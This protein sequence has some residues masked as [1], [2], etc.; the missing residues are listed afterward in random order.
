MRASLLA[1]MTVLLAACGS[2]ALKVGVSSTADIN[3]NEFDEPLAVVVRVYQLRDPQR[4][5]EATFEE[6]WREDY[7]VLGNDLVM[8]EE[9]TMD[10][11]YQ[12]RIDMPRHDQAKHVAA[13][14]VFRAPEDTHWRD[15]KPM[16]GN[17]LTRRFSRRVGVTLE[18]NRL[19]LD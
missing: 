18:Q 4:F 1:V 13:M 10:P 7:R 5:E 14:A 2:P 15:L 11:A 6:L 12:R 9:F 8:K 16:P 19:I 3:K 17:F